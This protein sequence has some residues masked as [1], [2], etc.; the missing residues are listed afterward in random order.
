MS[1]WALFWIVSTRNMSGQTS[2]Q[3]LLVQADL[4]WVIYETYRDAIM[5]QLG[6]PPLCPVSSC[7]LTS[8]NDLHQNAVT[9]LDL[10]SLHVLSY[11]SLTTVTLL[12]LTYASIL[13]LFRG[14]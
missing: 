7:F 13:V 12:H 14:Q 11:L 1:S 9:C 6:C 4:H 8:I 2:A 3:L 5:H 10:V